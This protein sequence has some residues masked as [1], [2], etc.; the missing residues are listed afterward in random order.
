MPK[1]N[2]QQYTKQEVY[3][4]YKT[5]VDAPL[6]FKEYFSIMDE[7][8]IEVVKHLLEGRDVR[9]YANLA[10]IGIRKKIGKTYIDYKATK[11]AGKKVVLPNTHSDFYISTLYWARRYAK[12]KTKGWFFKSSRFLARAGSKVMQTPGGHRTFVKRNDIAKSE[13]EAAELRKTK[14]YK[15]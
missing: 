5:Q 15:I 8:G 12:C 4:F 9:L 7:W 13:K 11:L 3:A 14:I 10:K 6:T 2:R 1:Y